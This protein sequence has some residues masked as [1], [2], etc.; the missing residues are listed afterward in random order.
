MT[1]AI[2]TQVERGEV[3]I[4]DHLQQRM[5][6]EERKAKMLASSGSFGLM[7]GFGAMVGGAKDKLLKKAEDVAEKVKV[8]MTYLK[9]HPK[10]GEPYWGRTSGLVSD[11]NDRKQ[12]QKLVDKRDKKHHMNQQG[13]RPAQL[14]EVSINSDTIRGVEHL[15]VNQSGGAQSTGGTSSNRINPIAA[16]NPNKPR[17]TTA[18]A[19]HLNLN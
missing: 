1:D 16:T 14:D 13:F 2:N 11:I 19:A 7:F 3:W 6:I 5:G 4:S 8:Y 18:G 12:L 9:P 10:G 15:R 17:Y